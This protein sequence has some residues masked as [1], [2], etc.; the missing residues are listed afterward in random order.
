MPRGFLD[1]D[2]LAHNADKFE[3]QERPR[4]D[5]LAKTGIIGPEDEVADDECWFDYDRP[6]AEAAYSMEI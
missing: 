4:I 3:R 2:W 6:A 5:G 1:D